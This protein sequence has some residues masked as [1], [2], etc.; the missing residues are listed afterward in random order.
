MRNKHLD[1][2]YIHTKFEHDK[3][4]FFPIYFVGAPVYMP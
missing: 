3:N 4:I 2:S 1:T